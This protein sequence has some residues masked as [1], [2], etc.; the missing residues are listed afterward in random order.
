LQ[1]SQR[2]GPGFDLSMGHKVTISGAFGIKPE[3][4]RM[5]QFGPA[6]SALRLNLGYLYVGHGP[7]S[8]LLKGPKN[9]DAVM[10]I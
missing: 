7:H 8:L 2:H 9:E 1:F 5:F 3:I 4:G 6:Y 10:K